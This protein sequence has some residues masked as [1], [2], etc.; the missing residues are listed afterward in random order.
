[1]DDFLK[2]YGQWGLVAGAAEGLGEAYSRALARRKMNLVLVDH[3]EGIL[4]RLSVNLEKQY[5]ISTLC[6]HLDLADPRAADKMMEA[7]VRIDCRLLVYNAAYSQVKPFLKNTPQELDN[8]IFVNTRTLIHLALLFS[9]ECTRANSTGGIL[10]M[11][12]LAALWGTQ[13]LGPYGATKAFDYILAEA[14]SHELKPYGIDV[15]AC[16][17]GAT[18]TPAYLGTKPEYGWPRPTVMEPG[19]VAEKAL[20]KFG[21]KVFYIPGFSNKITHFMLSRI[22]PRKISRKL[23]NSTTGRMYRDKI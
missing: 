14:L 8:Y 16:I 17:A 3:Q 20:S 23:F 22:F 21:K 4:E 18:A 13:L 15:M 19:E 6:L 11:S 7:V 5:G 9:Q 12:S 2:R 10:I 1:M